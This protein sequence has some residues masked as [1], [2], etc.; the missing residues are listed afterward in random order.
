MLPVFLP[1]SLR[2]VSFGIFLAFPHYPSLK[3]G[4]YVYQYYLCM[5]LSF[6]TTEGESFS[7]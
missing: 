2:G 7:F 6:G 1:V 5:Y 3:D 4:I